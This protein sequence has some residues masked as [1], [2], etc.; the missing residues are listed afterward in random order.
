M[1]KTNTYEAK[2][3]MVRARYTANTATVGFKHQRQLSQISRD[4]TNEHVGAALM[5][6][7]DR[8]VGQDPPTGAPGAALRLRVQG[9]STRVQPR[10]SAFAPRPL[11]P[12]RT[13][14][15]QPHWACREVGE[16]EH[17]S[18]GALPS[19]QQRTK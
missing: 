9:R 5:V 7:W 13:G 16:H 6:P 4:S 19:T 2:N 17:S 15:P 11:L 18:L 14:D 12:S 3:A 10:M 1:V 8:G